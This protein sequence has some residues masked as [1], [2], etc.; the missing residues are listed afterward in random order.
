MT[1]EEF[2]RVLP[3]HEDARSTELEAHLAACPSCAL[4]VVELGAL[5]REA[6][7]LQ[8]SESPSP[9]VWNSVE[10][11]LKKEGLI[12]SPQTAPV[13]RMRI[14]PRWRWLAPAAAALLLAVGALL[15]QRG[16][17]NPELAQ[18]APASHSSGA[19]LVGEDA[20][21]VRLVGERAP[22]MQAAIEADLRSVDDYVR[23]AEQSARSNPNDEV[24]QECLMAAYE[25][26]SMVYE[27][28][29]DRSLP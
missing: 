9:R 13:P 16:G 23:D 19:A 7:N 27:L 29:L 18:N 26:R 22:T 25:Q 3:E 6:R 2:E 11:A 15:Y 28:A 14:S 21:L 17:R 12:R 4:L 10:I 1:C 20:Q 24:A 8:A 5:S